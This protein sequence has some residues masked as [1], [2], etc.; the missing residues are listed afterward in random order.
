MIQND[1]LFTSG[2]LIAADEQ[3]KLENA[4]SA[5]QREAAKA[6]KKLESTEAKLNRENNEAERNIR[7]Q[8]KKRKREE[9]EIEL[10][11][12]RQATLAATAA[13]ADE[14]AC[15]NCEAQWQSSLNFFISS[16]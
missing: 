16:S 11:V 14:R 6:R 13:L 3:A 9:A 15:R 8:T 7:S 2:E 5:A 10:T 12:K 4:R 1:E